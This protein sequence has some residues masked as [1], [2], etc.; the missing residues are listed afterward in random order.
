MVA[1]D[2]L[3]VSARYVVDAYRLKDGAPEPFLAVWSGESTVN[4]ALRMVVRAEVLL[5][6]AVAGSA[7]FVFPERSNRR[8]S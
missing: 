7:A 8:D 2:I 6:Y 3:G 4:A 1:A 5:Q